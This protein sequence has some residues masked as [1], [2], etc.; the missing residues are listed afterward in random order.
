LHRRPRLLRLP[1]RHRQFLPPRRLLTQT[2][3][4]NLRFWP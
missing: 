4:R 2:L 1:Q 3:P